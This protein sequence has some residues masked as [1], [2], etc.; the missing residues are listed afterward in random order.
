MTCL[1]TACDSGG[2]VNSGVPGT[3]ASSGG[4]VDH[5]ASAAVGGIAAGAG[6]A[7][8]HHMING[9]VNKW[10]NRSSSGFRSGGMRSFRR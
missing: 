6:M 9:A 8:G 1:V 10:R 3:S 4:I 5:M 2:G 7:A